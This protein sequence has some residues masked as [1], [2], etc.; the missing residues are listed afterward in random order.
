MLVAPSEST[1]TT[2]KAA[3]LPAAWPGMVALYM[4]SP[5]MASPL[6]PSSRRVTLVYVVAGSIRYRTKLVATPSESARRAVTTTSWFAAG[7]TGL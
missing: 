3:S 5:A 1:A 6:D 7:Q 2:W 4:P